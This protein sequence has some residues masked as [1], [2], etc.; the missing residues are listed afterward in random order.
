VDA[1]L[2]DLFGTLVPPYRAGD[3][4]A[5]LDDI[6]EI[7][8]SGGEELRLGWHDTWDQRATGVFRSITD[9]LRALVP[10]ASEEALERARRR[11]LELTA[12]TLQP[13]SG[14]FEVLDW[15]AGEGV[16]LA[17]VTNCAPDVPDVWR[18]T[19]WARRFDATV[20]S[21]SIGVKKP[22]PEIYRAALD[23]LGVAGTDAVFVGDGSDRELQGAKAVGLTPV[24]VRNHA[25]VADGEAAEVFAAVH[26]LHALP[27]VLSG[28]RPR[29]AQSTKGQ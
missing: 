4:H 1:V 9:N 29:R 17:L 14:A 19:P 8:D 26:D 5:A 13:K 21:C 22:A 10:H 20:F 27:Q 23:E 25:P 2:F 24:L 15:L 18:E 7:L 3:H 16:A 6:A 28:L 12:V 11:Y